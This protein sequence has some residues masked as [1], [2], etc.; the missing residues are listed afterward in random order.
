MGNST[1]ENSIV[2]YFPNKDTQYSKCFCE[3]FVTEVVKEGYNA[4]DK[5]GY[6][7]TI[8]KQKF[9]N[10]QQGTLATEELLEI[11]MELGS[12]LICEV[13]IDYFHDSYLISARLIDTKN[14][15]IFNPI[16]IKISDKES[17]NISHIS[18]RVAHEIIK[19]KYGESQEEKMFREA[20]KVG[21]IQIGHLYVS[22]LLVNLRKEDISIKSNIGGF[23]DWRLP[24]ISDYILI[25]NA[26]ES[27][28]KE[29]YL[30][31]PE[32][33][34]NIDKLWK[35]FDQHKAFWVYEGGACE[36]R[37]SYFEPIDDRCILM[38]VRDI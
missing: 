25:Y 27:Y 26:I 20:F 10:F 34:Q 29:S 19:I 24:Y 32:A 3:A 37:N 13:A 5:T 15:Q 7:I 31:S 28:H 4:E 14:N 1:V 17:N 38:L 2:V 33:S 23:Q 18:K 22:T 9:K 16:F 35:T 6:I 12:P 36:G 30:Y 11:G 8:A 21:Y